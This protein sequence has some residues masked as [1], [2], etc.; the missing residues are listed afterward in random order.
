M[1]HGIGPTA[2]GRQRRRGPELS[3]LLVADKD[4]FTRRIA[5][6]IVFP[7]RQPVLV[8][9]ARP[10][11]A[12]TALRGNKPER[13]VRDDVRPGAGWKPA[14]ILIDCDDVLATVVSKAAEA[15][16]QLEVVGN[17][18]TRATGHRR[19]RNGDLGNLTRLGTEWNLRALQLLAKVAVRRVH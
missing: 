14:G 11:V 4:S 19:R 2:A 12:R 16:E 13:R 5:D 10:G 3:S 17:S 1:T 18:R 15:V 8:A 6:W 9:V 7:R